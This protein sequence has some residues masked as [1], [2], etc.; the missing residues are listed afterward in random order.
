MK[1]TQTILVLDDSGTP[2]V[3]ARLPIYSNYLKDLLDKPNLIVISSP[4]AISQKDK[5]Y[6]L[7]YHEMDPFPTRNGY[8]EV[9]VQDLHRKH[10]ITQ[11]FTHSEELVL[12]AAYLRDL[13]KIQPNGLNHSSAAFFR[14]KDVMKQATLNGGFPTP[15]FK[16]IITPS[17]IVAFTDEYGYP[18]IIKPVL[19]AASAGVLL[20]K[21]I[22][23]RNSYLKEEFYG[24][25]DEEHGQLD[26]SGDLMI[27]SFIKGEM[28]HVNG[29]AKNG[30]IKS[31]F[32]FKYFNTNLEFTQGHTYGNLFIPKSD[33]RW[34]LLVTAAQQVLSCLKCPD[35]LFFHLELFDNQNT[36][37]MNLT[38]CEI[39]A[40]RP[41]G[42][43]GNLIDQ[44]M[45]MNDPSW[46]S[47]QEYEFLVSIGID[48]KIPDIVDP[49]IEITSSQSIA[50]LMIPLRVGKLSS[51]PTIMPSI[52]GVTYIPIS[53]V[54]TIY[55]GYNI[56][57]VN[58]CARFVW[59]NDNSTSSEHEAQEAL[60]KAH[61]WF[62]QQVKY[63]NIVQEPESVLDTSM[64]R[65]K[66]RLNRMGS[67]VS[68]PVC[69]PGAF[70]KL[71]RTDSYKNHLSLALN[72]PSLNCFFGS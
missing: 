63:D 15:F 46:N 2:A 69:S 38:I 49:N 19:G 4:N 64:S 7:D 29:F 55:D 5:D 43:I 45:Q 1:S 26:H 39:A 12:R 14:N 59:Y 40:R 52:P 34:K 56:N 48:L 25:L 57:S 8:L 18:C 16:R 21:D 61:E 47:I 44:L 20:I 50:D 36:P 70:G 51:I 6:C 42:T 66:L 62:D 17:D 22:E 27:E 41:G 60:T 13:L 31:V 67:M 71:G 37:S 33:K 68:S 72:Q 53:K 24:L 9:L 32:P 30:K 54:G 28:Y 35:N 10:N 65:I 23:S 11:I 3:D 58:T